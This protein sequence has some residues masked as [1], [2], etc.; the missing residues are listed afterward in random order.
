M[1]VF[2]KFHH[3]VHHYCEAPT[4][5]CTAASLLE[6]KRKRTRNSHSPKSRNRSLAS[7]RQG[8]SKTRQASVRMQ[9]AAWSVPQ[10]GRWSPLHSSAP[11]HGPL[12]LLP[13][14]LLG[15]VGHRPNG[16]D[17]A[18]QRKDV[19]QDHVDNLRD[20]VDQVHVL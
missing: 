9:L 1:T 14:L 16:P 18:G 19:G 17:E 7:R 2:Y 20:A 8:L 10:D 3:R 11:A 4:P 5:P 12:Q 6:S 13:R 15:Q